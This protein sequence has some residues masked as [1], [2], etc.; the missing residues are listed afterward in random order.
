MRRKY[1]FRIARVYCTH[2]I[3]MRVSICMYIIYVCVCVRP[4]ICIVCNKCSTHTARM[5]YIYIYYYCCYYYYCYYY[6]HYYYCILLLF[7]CYKYHYFI[8]Y[9]WLMYA[10]MQYTFYAQYKYACIYNYNNY[11]YTYN[12]VYILYIVSVLLCV[13]FL[14]TSRIHWAF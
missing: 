1:A 13:C 11:I 10:C 5:I 8:I 12:Y 2:H 3:A 14:S 9:E 6:C 4:S 7:Y